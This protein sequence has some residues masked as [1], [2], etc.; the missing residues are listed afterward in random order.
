MSSKPT[1]FTPTVAPSSGLAT[2]LERNI[3]ALAERRREETASA[4]F[5]DKLADAIRRFAGSM[6]FVA[7]HAILVIMWVLVNSG[8]TALRPFDPTFVI[9]ATVASVEAIFLSTFIL[10]SQN[11]ASVAA[12]RRADLDLQISLLSE[13][14]VTRLIVLVARIADK[15]GIEEASNPELDELKRNVAPEAVLER[16]EE[17][18]EPGK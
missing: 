6:A 14:E 8:L 2:A 9:L 4:S 11:R 16:I 1:N 15:L 10:I 18:E 3:E 5:Q 12:D 7:I 13:H 17:R